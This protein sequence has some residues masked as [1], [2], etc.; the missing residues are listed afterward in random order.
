MGVALIK[1][2]I[3]VII[4]TL[5]G[6]RELPGLLEQLKLQTTNI[7]EVVIIDS[8]ST[9]RTTEI[10][11][12]FG[13]KVI[14]I[15]RDE[16][17]HGRTRNLAA[18]KAAGEIIIFMTQDAIPANKEMIHRLVTPLS[19]P[20][21]IISYAR[22]LPKAG[23]KITDRFLR[24]YN[25]HAQSIVKSKND[26][27]TMGIKTFQSSNVCAAY[28]RKE[29][30]ELRGFPEPIV[31][32]EDML[33]AAKAILKGYEVS[34]TSTACVLHSHN[35]S[36]VN[37]FKRY[38]DIGASLD[39]QP[40]IKAYGKAE[41]KGYDFI[42]SQLKHILS[43]KEYYYILDAILEAIF[44][45]VGYKLG[46]NHNLIPK[47]YKKHLGLQKNYWLNQERCN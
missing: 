8:Q 1:P 13:A 10:A 14:N 41:V 3:S 22:Q 36:Y 7:Q 2:K 30:E 47:L 23:T 16:F 17:D 20:N 31:S 21:I 27:K 5:N 38:F 11:T 12:S 25:Y 46:T 26:I 39:N 42:I 19:E 32:N 37:L 45:F 4:P 6:A 15:R 34:Y 44:K 18:A 35:Y 28:R 43:E 33:F 24:L 9:D 40:I 29:F